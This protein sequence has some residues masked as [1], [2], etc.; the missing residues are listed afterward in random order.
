MICQRD[1]LSSTKD[2]ATLLPLR[3]NP[4]ELKRIQP[5]LEGGGVE[6]AGVF[7]SRA[8][9]DAKPDS[10]LDLLVRFK[11]PVGFF[12]FLR[13]ERMISETLGIPVDLVTEA[14]LSPYIREHVVENLHPIY[15]TVPI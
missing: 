11:K 13:L 2:R 4:L 1:S 5:I 10:D 12:R 8:R 6:F 9:T 7:G 3:M 15:A 14:S